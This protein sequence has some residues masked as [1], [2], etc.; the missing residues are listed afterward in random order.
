MKIQKEVLRSRQNQTV[1]WMASL[2]EKKYRDRYKSFVAEGAKLTF[3]ACDASLPV[4]YVVIS[5][6]KKETYYERVVSAFSSPIYENCE[7]IIMADEV[8]SKIISEKAPQGIISIIKY[9]DFFQE[10]DIIYK[11][12]FFLS[13]EERAIA[14]C[15]LR[16]PGNLG[17]VMRS[18]VAFG[19]DH[20]IL[21][22]D[23]ADVYNS[24]TVRSAMGS[25]FRV[26]ITVVS[27]FLSFVE[28]AKANGRRLF[29]AEL[30]DN[31]VSISE[32]G[33]R[34]DDVFIIGNEGHGIPKEISEASSSSVYIPISKKTESLNASVAASVF[35][36]EQ[37]KFD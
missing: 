5:E 1:K 6:S 36:W 3:E 23:S 12:D 22:S 27:D 25:L 8:F 19:V 15:S 26:K 30:T 35:M 11:E 14:L 21:S 13:K 17:A 10:L 24:K 20:I 32:L 28:S 16:D 2:S 29:S 34:R 7:L 31:A 18:S 9:L 33:L 37:S 4:T